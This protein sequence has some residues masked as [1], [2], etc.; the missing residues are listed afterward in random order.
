MGLQPPVGASRGVCVQEKGYSIC[1]C[2]DHHTQRIVPMVNG[3]DTETQDVLGVAQGQ[4]QSLQ[5]DDIAQEGARVADKSHDQSDRAEFSTEYR[6]LEDVLLQSHADR[7][8]PT[9]SEQERE[10]RRP[11]EEGAASNRLL[12]VLNRQNEITYMLLRQQQLSLLPPKSVTVF[13]GDILQFKSFMMSFEHNIEA[14]TDSGQDRLFYLEQFTRGPARDLVRSCQ[15]MGGE[16]G[17]L[18]AKRS[19]LEHFGNEYKISTAYIEKVLNWP[20]IKPEDPKALNEYSLYLKGCCNAMAKMNYMDELNVA[21]TLKAIVTKLPY[22]LR[23]RWR[24]KAQAK[25]EDNTSRITFTDLVQFIE[26]QAKICSNPIF[27]DIQE[28][29][30]SRNKRPNVSKTLFR[31][32]STYATN[33]TTLSTPAAPSMNSDV[34]TPCLCCDGAHCLEICNHFKKKTHREKL[35]LLKE[36][37]LCFGCLCKGHMSKDCKDRL[38][39]NICN[40]TH[41]NVLHINFGAKGHASRSEEQPQKQIS[42]VSSNACGHTGAGYSKCALS[43]LPVQVKSVKGNK[44][45]QTYALLDPGSSATFCTERLAQ[46]LCL[47][48]KSTTVLLRT[49][50]HEKPIKSVLISGLEVSELNGKMFIPLPDVYT[51]KSMPVTKENIPTQDDLKQWPYLSEVQLPHIDCDID[52]LIGMNAANVMEP[53]QVINSQEDGPYAVRTLLGWVINGPLGGSNKGVEMA[54]VTANRISL[55]DLQELLVSQY[56]TDFNERAYEEKSEMSVNVKKFLNIVN[57]SV[58]MKEGHYCINLP[59]KADSITMPNNR[60]VAEQRLCNLKRKFKR[61]PNY[62]KEYTEF[63]SDV[64]HKGYA[65]KVPSA[66][67]N[68]SDG[69]VWYIPH[70]GVYHPKKKTLRVVFDCGATFQGTSL[71][72]ELLQ[73]PN[74]TNTLIGVLTRFREQPVALMADIQAMF[75]QV[76]V[77]ESDTDF[78]RFLWWPQGKVDDAPVEY[79]MTVHLF[80]AVSSPSIAN[81]ALRKTAQD[82]TGQCKQLSS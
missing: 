62:Q 16:Q 71:N 33:V 9:L 65:E 18:R 39:C 5:A 47:E 52:L 27:G 67:L 35:N 21:S 32:K 17:Y 4:A 6:Q 3:E 79:R 58:K 61:D 36:K 82:C 81:F 26:K 7:A 66:Q 42:K 68:R 55:G 14:K 80:G 23:D 60:V 2:V 64:I 19:L 54:T 48:G 76:K 24:T 28:P 11:V 63:L 50:A 37:G 72:S 57:E 41:P 46:K 8:G 77:T 73:G 51:Q 10:Y 56:N 15:H 12:S 70:H 69:K 1:H 22:K 45:S 53:W 43:I 78:L 34:K 40:Q 74:L 13:D 38:T 31:P 29:V 75:H 30:A 20:N 59:F 25:L 44:I 49:M